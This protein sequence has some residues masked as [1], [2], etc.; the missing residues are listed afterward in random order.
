MDVVVSLLLSSLCVAVAAIFLYRFVFISTQPLS[1]LS[2]AFYM[3]CSV[4]MCA[5]RGAAGSLLLHTVCGTIL[6]L[7]VQDLF[8]LLGTASM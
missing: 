8:R 3:L 4:L 2:Y 6:E 5:P 7:A 1:R